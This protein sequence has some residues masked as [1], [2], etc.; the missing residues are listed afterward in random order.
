MKKINI[1]F[2]YSAKG[3]GGIV[4]NLSLLVNNLD[5][6]RFVVTVV[7]LANEGDD[8]SDI[9]METGSGVTF[10][11]IDEKRR[12][13]PD[14]VRKIDALVREKGIDVLSC[15]GYKA[16]IYGMTIR[17]FLGN[18]VRMVAMV[19]GWTMSGLKVEIYHILDKLVLRSF[20]KIILVSD[21]LRSGLAGWMIPAG[22]IEVV[23]NAIPQVEVKEGEERDIVRKALGVPNAVTLAGFVGRMSREKDLG[24]TVKALKE[25]V[26]RGN[27][28]KLMVVGEGPEK[29]RL[30]LLADDL[31]L[32]D[33]V[34]FTGFQKDAGRYF[35]AFDIYLST[36]VKEGLPNSVLEAQANGVPCVVTDIRGN[37]DIIKDGANGLLAKPGDCKDVADK[38]EKLIGDKVICQ[39]FVQAGKTMIKVNFSM[40]RRIEKLQG[41]YEALVA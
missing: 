30:A 4:R 19:H 18:R 1:M 12:F 23:F 33:R 28:I 22:K 25:L 29:E 31:G 3:F 38:I 16:D 40:E 13:D 15:H 35:R 34:I 39:K 37:N 6:E 20:D 10:V 5:K 26:S 32:Q 27:N 14:S 36:S 9:K 17:T 11:R 24:T 8:D 21:G 7:S 41:I 2:L